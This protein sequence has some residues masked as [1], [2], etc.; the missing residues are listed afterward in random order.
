M[1]KW[2][3]VLQELLYKL[4]EAA[5]NLVLPW[6]F[7]VQISVRCH[8][9]HLRRSRAASS[10]NTDFTKE[11]LNRPCRIRTCRPDSNTPIEQPNIHRRKE[12]HMGNIVWQEF[13]KFHFCLNRHVRGYRFYLTITDSYWQAVSSSHLKWWFQPAQSFA[14]APKPR[15]ISVPSWN[16]DLGYSCI[17]CC[18]QIVSICDLGFLIALGRISRVVPWNSASITQAA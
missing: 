4:N 2:L 15:L 17:L 6:V 13:Y 12:R 9:E 16:L 8:L 1:G 18:P 11:G 3:T 5:E 10:A 14:Q 7:P